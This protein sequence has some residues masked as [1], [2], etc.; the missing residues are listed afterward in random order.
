M[1]NL[2]S[3]SGAHWANRDNAPRPRQSHE[4]TRNP[5]RAG[6]PGSDDRGAPFRRRPADS[7]DEDGRRADADEL[8][9]SAYLP[10]LSPTS[11]FADAERRSRDVAPDAGP[12]SRASDAGLPSHAPDAGLPSRAPDA[13]LPLRAPGADL[14]SRAPKAGLPLRAPDAGLPVRPPDAGLPVRAPGA[15]LSGELPVRTAARRSTGELPVTEPARHHE[16]RPAPEFGPAPP[17]TPGRVSFGV[18]AGPISPSHRATGSDASASRPTSPAHAAPLPP[19]P[20][21]TAPPGPATSGIGSRAGV[22]SGSRAYVSDR[23]DTAHKPPA[24]AH[25][26]T[27]PSEPPRR[28]SRPLVVATALLS[29]LVLLGGVLAGMAYFSGD[30]TTVKR[31][32]Q[33]SA[34][35]DKTVTAPLQGR[36]TAQ[37]D[38]VAATTKATVRTADLGDDLYRITAPDHSGVRPS[39]VLTD[40]RVQ[41]Q[42]TSDGKQAGGNVDVELS[43]KVTWALRFTGGADEQIVDLSGG[44][45]SGL[46][47]LAG[48]RRFQLKLPKPIGT[49]PVHVT[50]AIEDFSIVSPVGNPVRVQ[51]NGGAKTIAAGKVTL[52]DVKPG[53]TLTP[54][55]WKVTNRYDVNAAARVTLLSVSSAQ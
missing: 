10:N 46:D 9:P 17:A 2:P 32:L 23:P 51:L 12:P 48:V 26:A 28:R 16:Y 1:A 41:L 11:W 5:E 53:S 31:I 43:S 40:D 30:D 3:M 35:D 54:K 15:G 8:S 14:P 49:V 24:T 33:G 38:L 19:D 7:S 6:E 45:V 36:T 20:V 27:A 50:G 55:D 34:G 25:R 52:K 13:G 18:S 37:F 21:L 42:L 47:V 29:A 44:Q 39:A 22:R 4:R